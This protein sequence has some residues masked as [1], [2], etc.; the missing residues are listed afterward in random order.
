MVD[1]IETDKRCFVT[2]RILGT[3]DGIRQGVKVFEDKDFIIVVGV[4]TS[5]KCGKDYVIVPY[6]GLFGGWFGSYEVSFGYTKPAVVYLVRSVDFE[7]VYP[8][9]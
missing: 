9:P 1:N 2:A 5:Y 4:E 6:T 7:G 3:K 8:P